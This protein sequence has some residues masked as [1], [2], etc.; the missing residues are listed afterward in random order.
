M[1]TLTEWFNELREPYRSWFLEAVEMQK[2]YISSYG[3]HSADTLL[4]AIYKLSWN[5]EELPRILRG[6][7]LPTIYVAIRDGKG[8]Q[9]LEPT[10]WIYEVEI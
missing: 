8:A 6:A 4:N 2:N 5:D 1:K 10:H 7:S 9:Y 3:K